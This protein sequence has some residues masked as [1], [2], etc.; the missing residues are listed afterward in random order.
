MALGLGSLV[1]W[2]GRPGLS[3]ASPDLADLCGMKLY[4]YI[5]CKGV[6]S[7]ELC[8]FY[9]DLDTT[10]PLRRGRSSM[11]TLADQTVPIWAGP[12]I[13]PCLSFT[14]VKEACQSFL[15]EKFNE[16]KGHEYIGLQAT[17]LIRK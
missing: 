4:I 15:E 3:A 1:A 12:C 7:K 6:S 11:E 10:H 13:C 16:I 9:R 5:F 2:E 8:V 14:P 17:L